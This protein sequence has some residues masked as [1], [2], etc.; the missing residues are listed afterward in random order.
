VIELV[1]ASLAQ[2]TVPAV[3]VDQV[4][5]CY[6]QEDDLSKSDPKNPGQGH[7][8]G[9]KYL[10]AWKFRPL[11][12]FGVS[13]EPMEVHD[14]HGFLNGLTFAEQHLNA[15]GSGFFSRRSGEVRMI[16]IPAALLPG[17]MN[18]AQFV[19]TS[20]GKVTGMGFGFCQVDPRDASVA[21]DFWKSQSET[22][23]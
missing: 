12:S 22:L 13:K 7:P 11:A 14:P 4:M 9:P 6:I 18:K 23:P 2:P 17:Q 21:F 1:W 3:A 8:V 10:I 15:E 20:Q 19:L 5:A 16:G